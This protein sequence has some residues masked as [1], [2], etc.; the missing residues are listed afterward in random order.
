MRI[1]GATESEMVYR[2]TMAALTQTEKLHFDSI[3]TEDQYFDQA[4]LKI[5]KATAKISPANS[6]YAAWLTSNG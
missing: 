3:W 4:K 1:A 5:T 6:E 2:F